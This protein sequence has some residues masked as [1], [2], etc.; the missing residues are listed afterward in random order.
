[1]CDSL[2]ISSPVEFFGTWLLV[3]VD[4]NNDDDDVVG[5]VVFDAATGWREEDDKDVREED[6]V[7]PSPLL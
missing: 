4:N 7:R 5:F 2:M 1:M 3:V 6:V